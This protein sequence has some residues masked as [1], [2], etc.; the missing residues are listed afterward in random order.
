MEGSDGDHGRPTKPASGAVRGPPRVARVGRGGQEGSCK[1]TQSRS[2]VRVREWG[3]VGMVLRGWG[4]VP[5]VVCGPVCP[6]VRL[7]EGLRGG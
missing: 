1:G 7:K 2:H 3:G 5:I 6:S 4:R